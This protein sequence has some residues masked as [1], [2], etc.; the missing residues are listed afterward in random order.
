VTLASSRNLGVKSLAGV[1]RVAGEAARTVAFLIAGGAL[2]LQLSGLD[3]NAPVGAD[4][5]SAR[6]RIAL[7]LAFAILMLSGV[8]GWRRCAAL[9]KANA[10][11]LALPLLAIVSAAWAPDPVVAL[12][13]AS[14]FALTM[15]AAVAVVAR[16][17]G[18]SAFR[19]LVRTVAAG[20]ALSIAYVALAPGYGVHQLT[21]GAQS[22]HAGD[23]RGLFVH[24]T[25]LGQLAAL[26]LGL[27]VY[28]GSQALHPA[29]RWGAILASLLCLLMARSGGGWV[30]AAVLMALPPLW[31]AGR[32]L[33]HW[34][35]P[36]TAAA[37]FAALAL[38]V[39]LAP[40]LW[41]LALSALGKDATLTGR[42]E[43][44][45]MMAQAAAR[46]PWLGYGY[47]TGFREVVAN[48]IQAHSPYGFVPNAQNGYLDVVL[49]LGLAG[50]AVALTALGLAFRRAV[51]L[52]LAAEA[53]AP[54]LIVAFIAEMNVVEAALIS[55][56]DIF[57][58]IYATAAIA[59]GEM[60]SAIAGPDVTMRRGA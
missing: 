23:W 51:R 25:A 39:L 11:L 35:L 9:L 40:V 13:R 43:L 29:L 3:L 18:A 26:C 30:S 58:L 46:R 59:S 44:W 28:A 42:S 14:A 49:S 1:W 22:V 53:F 38:V 32:R 12:R 48:L 6:S 19:F 5:A 41:P 33:T 36:A 34:N 17:P 47:G 37:A 24:R 57:V 56:N 20:V 4:S 16:S 55:A 45:K 2:S 10:V 7:G 52:A 8:S 21:D 15:L 27:A 60:A 31:T 54:L 50:L